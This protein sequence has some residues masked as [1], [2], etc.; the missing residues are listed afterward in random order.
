MNIWPKCVRE[1]ENEDKTIIICNGS[2]IPFG[3]M[4]NIFHHWRCVKCGFI[5]TGGY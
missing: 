5:F 4:H 2:M 3:F 1:K